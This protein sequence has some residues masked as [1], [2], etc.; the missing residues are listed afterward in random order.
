MQN[1]QYILESSR[2]LY[3]PHVKKWMKLLSYNFFFSISIQLYVY[4]SFFKMI[5]INIKFLFIFKG[6]DKEDYYHIEIY[7][8]IFFLSK[9]EKNH[10][11]Y[12]SNCL[13]V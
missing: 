11:K 7:L 6:F 2:C 3:E 13:C 5:I 4:F 8:F 9:F 10:E 1:S 12:T